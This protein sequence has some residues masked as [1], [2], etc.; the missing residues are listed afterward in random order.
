MGR[1]GR[2]GKQA[3]RGSEDQV[4]ELLVCCVCE[5]ERGRE[6]VLAHSIRVCVAMYYTVVVLLCI[7]ELTDNET[8]LCPLVLARRAEPS[9]MFSHHSV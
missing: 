7:N 3:G 6:G 9:D 1:T 4:W 8:L 2:A 5:R